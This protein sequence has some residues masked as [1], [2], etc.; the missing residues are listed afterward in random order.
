MFSTWDHAQLGKWYGAAGRE[1][2]QSDPLAEYRAAVDR[3]LYAATA[4]FL[5]CV[6][7]LLLR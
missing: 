1:R 6:L 2:E 5:A 4:A 7:I 3:L